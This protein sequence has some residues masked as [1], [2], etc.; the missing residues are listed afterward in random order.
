MATP[1]MSGQPSGRPPPRAPA[2]PGPALR[3]P[4]PRA[5]RP[6]AARTPAA[7]GDRTPEVGPASVGPA[8]GSH[9]PRPCRTATRRGPPDTRPVVGRPTPALVAARRTG[10]TGVASL[11]GHLSGGD[12]RRSVLE[13]SGVGGRPLNPRAPGGDRYRL[14]SA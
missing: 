6:R 12:S 10:K 11:V 9:R 3:T 1:W 2:A 13:A 7:A 5:P 14:E 8:V 4:P